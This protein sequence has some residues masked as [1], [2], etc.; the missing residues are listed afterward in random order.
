[1][2][3][4][5]KSKGI[6]CHEYK[7]FEHIQIKCIKFLRNPKKGYNATFSDKESD[8][9]SEFDQA[10]NVVAFI[11]RIRSSSNVHDDGD[12]SDYDLSDDAL[13]E[14]YKIMNIKWTD[15]CKAGEKQKGEN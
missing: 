8:E 11:T 3:K 7:G 5:N 10:N 14:A 1:M 13:V 12:T 9:E 4:K 2:K 6:Q 15:E